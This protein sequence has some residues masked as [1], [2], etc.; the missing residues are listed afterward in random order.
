MELVEGGV[1]AQTRQVLTN[2]K[3]VLEN[4]R[5]GLKFV[6]KTTVFLQDMG[7]FARMNGVYAEFFPKTHPHA[8]R[9]RLRAYPKALWWKSNALRCSMQVAATNYQLVI[10]ITN[11]L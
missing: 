1:E 10:R 11:L 4:S 2:P 7:D 3:H 5:L 8:A 9:S 6:V